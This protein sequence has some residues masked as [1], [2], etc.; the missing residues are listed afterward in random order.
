MGN[1][2][3]EG[4]ELKEHVDVLSKDGYVLAQGYYYSRPLKV[5]AFEDYM[6]TVHIAS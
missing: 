2:I 4:V 1:W 5:G 6:K 3:A